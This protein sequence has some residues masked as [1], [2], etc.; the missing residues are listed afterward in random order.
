MQVDELGAFAVVSHSG[1]E[2]LE[3]RALVGGELV[4]GVPQVV[5]VNARQAGN[6]Q[7]GEP[8]AAAKFEWD[9]GEPVEVTK[10]S[11]EGRGSQ[12][13]C[14]RRSGT[15]SSRKADTVIVAGQVYA[16]LSVEEA[17]RDLSTTIGSAIGRLISFIY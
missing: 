17:I 3:V 4:S 16:T 9:S 8:D 7:G 2:F 15:I 11:A 12:S 14:L 5:K 6:G 1:H 10:T 13:R